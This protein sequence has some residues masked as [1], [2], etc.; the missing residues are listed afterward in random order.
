LVGDASS[1]TNDELCSTR[2]SCTLL[3][4]IPRRTAVMV[5]QWIRTR[6]EVAWERRPLQS[7]LRSNTGSV[8]P[9]RSCLPAACSCLCGCT[10][11]YQGAHD[12]LHALA[13]RTCL[14]VPLGCR[15]VHTLGLSTP[16]PSSL[17][18]H[19]A[20]CVLDLCL[21]CSGAVSFDQSW[22]LACCSSAAQ[23]SWRL[24]RCVRVALRFVDV[25]W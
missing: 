13:C 19:C 21:T 23:V 20:T 22:R 5:R 25:N 15:C 7:A 17:S 3:P 8:R 11:S 9:G 10:T 24:V 6:G 2:C 18:D 1:P 16:L 4:S 14:C 12:C